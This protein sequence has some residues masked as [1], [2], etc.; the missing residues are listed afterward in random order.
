MA[1][2]KA[3]KTSAKVTAAKSLKAEGQARVVASRVKLSGK[4][5]RA[6]GHLSASTRRS[7]AKRDGKGS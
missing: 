1:K 2:K 3:K 5:T 4:T 6:K 7:Q